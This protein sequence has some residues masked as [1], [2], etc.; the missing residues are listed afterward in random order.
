MFER[1]IATTNS[2]ECKLGR[3][4]ISEILVKLERFAFNLSELL[5]RGPFETS[6]VELIPT[7]RLSSILFRDF[8][9]VVRELH[10]MFLIKNGVNLSPALRIE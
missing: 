6:T 2:T 9:E 8:L 10:G 1:L 3:C 5:G 7:F 4:Y